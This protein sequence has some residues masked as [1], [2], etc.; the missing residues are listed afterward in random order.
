MDAGAFL[1]RPSFE[2]AH[3]GGQPSGHVPSNAGRAGAAPIEYVCT[4][5]P[6]SVEGT[7]AQS[8]QRGLQVRDHHR[9]F[10][11]YEV[12]D[13]FVQALPRLLVHRRLAAPVPRSAESTGS[14]QR[15]R[16]RGPP[17]DRTGAPAPRR[18]GDSDR[19]IPAMCRRRQRRRPGRSCPGRPHPDR[20]GPSRP[21]RR[22]AA[23]RRRIGGTIQRAAGG[24]FDPRVH[25]IASS[26]SSPPTVR[27]MLRRYSPP[28][29]KRARVIWPIEHVCTVVMS[30]SNRLPRSRATRC[31]RSR[32]GPDRSALRS[33]QARR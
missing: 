3:R 20:T 10:R 17:R 12:P 30:A 16:L 1:V 32:A 14:L 11:L 22:D 31:S 29:S 26:R 33:C 25:D 24:I 4:A 28:T 6:P 27:H 7:A 9:P 2:K 5:S 13:D 8:L 23:P 21:T 19:H 18:S 15:A